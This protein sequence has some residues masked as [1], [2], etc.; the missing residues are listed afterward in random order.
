M[1][2]CSAQRLGLSTRWLRRQSSMEGMVNHAV[3]PIRLRIFRNPY[4][5]FPFRLRRQARLH[6]P[7]SL[8]LE[9]DWFL[10]RK[11]GFSLRSANV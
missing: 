1:G 7:M 6:L 9:T 5:E 8:F 11:G 2:D 10:V 4:T 3:S